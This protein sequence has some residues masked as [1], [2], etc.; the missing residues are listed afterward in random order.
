MN[1]RSTYSVTGPLGRRPGSNIAI[2]FVGMVI[3]ARFSGKKEDA[4]EGALTC[5]KKGIGDISPTT[6]R[7]EVWLDRYPHRKVLR[8]SD[9]VGASG[10]GGSG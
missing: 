6:C 1:F 2:A 4:G 3:G 9:E 7:P 10:N 5:F 8:I